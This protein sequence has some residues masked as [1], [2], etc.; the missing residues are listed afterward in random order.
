MRVVL[1][2]TAESVSQQAAAKVPDS[3]LMLEPYIPA[4]LTYI[5]GAVKNH[6]GSLVKELKSSGKEEMLQEMKILARS[7]CT[8]YEEQII[9][10]ESLQFLKFV[11]DAGK[12]YMMLSASEF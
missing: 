3:M 6:S 8:F 10:S 4:L 7:V 12:P 5:E 2:V 1:C 9:L 11:V